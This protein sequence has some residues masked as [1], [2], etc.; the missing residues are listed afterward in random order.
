VIKKL[1]AIQSLLDTPNAVI[2]NVNSAA[3][4]R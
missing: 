2:T 4:R 1:V 3:S